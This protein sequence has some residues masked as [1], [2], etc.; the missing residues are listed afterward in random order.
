M[1]MKILKDRRFQIGLISLAVV[2]GLWRLV[3][4]LSPSAAQR[5][6]DDPVFIDAVTGKTF[7]AALHIGE[8]IPVISPYTGRK[9]G[10]PAAWSWWSRSGKPLRK[11]QAVLMNKW[12]GKSGPT[13]APLSG[14][15]VYPMEARPYPGERP[16]PTKT[17]Y[18]Q[19][20]VSQELGNPTSQ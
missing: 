19:E 20:I 11:P 17:Q 12:I 2:F 16:P 4:A 13:F 10:Y 7:R 3:A 9:T 5:A 18:E 15:L 8:T 6:S 1:A 14:R